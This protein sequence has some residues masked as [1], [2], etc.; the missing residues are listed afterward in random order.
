MKVGEIVYARTNAD[1]LNEVLGTNY[2]AW[3]KSS[4]MLPDNKRLWMI[5]LGNFVTTAGWKN[6]LLGG[7]KLS[8]I[9]VGGDYTFDSHNTYWGARQSGKSWGPEIRVVFDIVKGSYSRKYIFRGVFRLNRE[10]SSISENVWDLIM[11]EYNF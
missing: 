9:H 7:T 1:L 3:M 11:D 6:T 2:K 4:I 8:E 10:E 5:E